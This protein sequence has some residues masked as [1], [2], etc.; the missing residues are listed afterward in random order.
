MRKVYL[1]L[2]MAAMAMGSRAQSWTA[3]TLHSS[4]EDIPASAFLYH[5]GQKMFFTKGTTWG[6]H[7]ALTTK[8][9]EA[10]LYELQAQQDAGIYRLH[11]SAAAATGLLGRNSESDLYTDYNN[12][13]GWGSYFKI[14]KNAETGLYRLTSAPNDNWG[15]VADEANG[16]SYGSY[17]MGW[18]PNNVDIDQSGNSL[19]TNVGIFMLPPETQG[20]QADWQFITPEDFNLYTALVALYNKLN[21]AVEIG[22][23]ESELSNYAGLLSSTDLEAINAAT[24]AVNNMVLNYAY[25]HATPDNP[26]DVTSTI[27]NPT[28]N[29][30][31][32]TEPEGWIDEFQNMKIQNNKAYPLWD[33]AAGAESTLEGLN[34]FSQNWTASNTAPI[35]PSNIYQIIKDLP[36]GTYRLTA[37]CIATS[38]SAN[39]VVSGAEL[40]AIS[41][42]I[43]SAV[44]IDKNPYGGSGSAS[45]H[46]Y[47]VELTHFGGDLTIGY[48]FTPGYVKWFAIDN[49]N[50]YYCGPVANPGLVALNSNI[51]GVQVYLDDEDLY[52][53]SATTRTQVEQALRAAAE[54]AQTGDSDACSAEADKLA[55]LIK[56]I[57]EEVNSYK[58]LDALVKKAAKDKETFANTQ[59][60]GSQL[61][62]MYD[63]YLGAYEERTASI[64]EITQWNDAYIPFLLN[65][66]RTAMANASEES[67]VEITVLAKNMDF[68]QNSTT[69]GWT[70]TT[71]NISN[72]G[73]Y[74][75]NNQT[76]EVWQNTFNAVQVLENMPA[77]KY[78]LSGK[79]F[80][81][82]A[83]ADENYTNYQNGVDNVTTYMFLQDKAAKVADWAK[84]VRQ[85]TSAPAEGYIETAA[86][87]GI[88]LCNTQA[89]AALAFQNDDY[90][91][92][93]S[94]YLNQDGTL[95]FGL[96]NNEITAPANQ[97][98]VWTDLHLVYYGKSNAAL[99]GNLTEII[100]AASEL[101]NS[102]GSENE[103]AS[104][105]LNEAVQAAENL[106]IQNSEEQILAAINAL[107]TA[108]AY[109]NE[110]K[111]LEQQ[112]IAALSTYQEKLSQNIE[113]D[114]THFEE[115]LA[116]IDAAVGAEEFESN[117]KMQAWLDELPKAWTAYVQFNHLN[118]T[119]DAPED[120]TAALLNPSF[121]QGTNDTNGATG[122]TFVWENN[123]TSG[124]I[125]WNNTT[126]QQGSGNAYEFWNINTLDMSQQV[127][128]LAEGYYRLSA[129][130]LYRAGNNDAA[131]IQAFVENPDNATR[132]SLYANNL[133]VKVT[134]CYAGAASE[135][136]QTETEVVVSINGENKYVPNSMIAA[137]NAFKAG[138]YQSSINIFVEKGQTL[139][140]GLRTEGEPV[141]NCWAVFDNFKLEYLGNG[142]APNAV[143]SIT[144]R[145]TAPKA[146]YD[147]Q[148][149]RVRQTQK[150][151]YIIDGK[152]TIVK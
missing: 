47:E 151:L 15:S 67:P 88:W 4:S 129:N 10:L 126:Q 74:K 127:V 26:F 133:S 21:E 28:F 137:G 8:A 78:V 35:A 34:N 22:Y 76:A 125:G 118:A 121:D 115:V 114:D 43:R 92:Q 89:S 62:D 48:G 6:S 57:K 90:K 65:G 102:I 93:V 56:V 71:G 30:A 138:R 97:W 79:A 37:N 80:F 104:S 29:G 98:S 112:V 136:E 122:W 46:K 107:N 123:G 55:A 36:Q 141:A 68:A 9:G 49:V 20:L 24:A 83:N 3:P 128:G 58:I 85:S 84:G 60:L 148:G 33:D 41:G 116:E 63:Q 132:L 25:N 110:G 146:I 70:V 108:I 101:A 117:E 52:V 135:G 51:A 131:V 73:T 42:T 13:A 31:R 54:V 147:L 75:V 23:S 143:E 1:S 91:S 72:G 103:A 86:G 96:R 59:N 113:S 81:R 109:A 16:T 44:P 139:T 5:T 105:K 19:N 120:I 124:H 106:S 2:A 119:A 18:N 142:S 40:Y 38:A 111:R 39:L 95:S 87:S 150:G 53:F 12:Q 64:A 144:D 61:G 140:I 77:G 45:P 145:L 11:S 14:E 50:L 94:G 100:A 69:E 152:K 32:G 134:N 99:F 130:A 149:R 27:A 17:L 82:S 66:V 7:A